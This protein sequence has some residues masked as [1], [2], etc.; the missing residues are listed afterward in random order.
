MVVSGSKKHL[1]SNIFSPAKAPLAGWGVDVIIPNINSEYYRDCYYKYI[2]SKFDD[3]KLSLTRESCDILIDLLYNI[4]EPVNIVCSYILDRSDQ[5]DIITDDKISF[6]IDETAIARGSRF[7]EFLAKMTESEQ[8]VLVALA[9]NWPISSPKSKYFLSKVKD[10]SPSAVH[11][12]IKRFEN[13]AEIYNFPDGYK[14]S[15]SLLARY[16]QLR[17]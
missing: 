7:E 16:L 3:K 12:I 1:L 9:K 11:K 8:K 14:L 6:F 17:R 15:D 2:S 13:S 10:V 5:K 4:P